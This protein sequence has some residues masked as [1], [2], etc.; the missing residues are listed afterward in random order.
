MLRSALV[1]PVTA[2]LHIDIVLSA[3]LW[4]LCPLQSQISWRQPCKDSTPW[5]R[6]DLRFA[7]FSS[8]SNILILFWNRLAC[9]ST[10][11]GQLSRM[12][13][14]AVAVAE[15]HAL[16]TGDQLPLMC[17]YLSGV[18]GGLHASI[19]SPALSTACLFRISINQELS[20]TKTLV[21]RPFNWST[22]PSTACLPPQSRREPLKAFRPEFDEKG[23][24]LERRARVGSPHV[25]SPL[26]TELLGLVCTNM[27]LPRG[28][29]RR[30]AGFFPDPCPKSR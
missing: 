13:V 30:I 8:R 9:V 16:N 4:A 2:S 19:P 7:P 12:P 1:L 15:L 29:A 27:R 23:W 14:I 3:M 10:G 22:V 20:A 21:N 24:R 28:T 17:K 25:S 5:M 26:A 18:L 11:L 6:Q